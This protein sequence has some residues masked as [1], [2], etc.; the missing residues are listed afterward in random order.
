MAFDYPNVVPWGRS[1][2]EYVRMFDLSADDL[3]RRILGCGDGPASF[4]AVA[5]RRGA[6]VVSVDPLYALSAEQLRKRIDETFDQ[7]M[8]QTRHERHRFVWDAI[9]SVEELG[10]IRMS[11]MEEFL[12]DFEAGRAA[13]RYVTGELPGLPFESD[14]FEL[15][16]CSHLLLFYAE[17]LDLELHVRSVLELLRVA[18][19]VRVFPLVDVNARPSP[20]L[21]PLLGALRSRG[22][23]AEVQGVPYEFQRG[24]NEML[25]VLR[26]GSML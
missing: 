2:D 3:R 10:R 7:V 8:G 23:D 20:H 16:L 4:N 12:G 24:G 25:R 11:A 18:P 1:C 14:A 17:R 22:H 26:S 21:E 15:A 19:E 5:T 6:R 9:G 13:G